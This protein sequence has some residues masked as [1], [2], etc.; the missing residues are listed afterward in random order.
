MRS[1]GSHVVS[2]YHK[3]RRDLLSFIREK[4]RG[5]AGRIITSRQDH[6]LRLPG[7]IGEFRGAGEHLSV[8]AEGSQAPEN[9]MAGLAAKI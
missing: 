5:R 9:Q 3:R 7:E 1:G 6:T 2:L 8:N 4:Q